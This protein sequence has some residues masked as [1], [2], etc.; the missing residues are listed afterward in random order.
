MTFK[1][2]E[3]LS[4][5]IAGH[6]AAQIIR[7]DMLAGDRIQELRVAGELGSVV[8]CRAHSCFVGV[9]DLKIFADFRRFRFFAV[10]APRGQFRAPGPLETCPG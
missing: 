1:A 8:R 10:F 6:L 7:G 5:Q 3:S 4:E 2:R 9:D